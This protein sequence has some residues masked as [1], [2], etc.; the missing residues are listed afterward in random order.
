MRGK[1][2][3]D[4]R[5]AI[6]ELGRFFRNICS[7]TLKVDALLKMEADIAL[8][9]C[10]LESLYPPSFFDVMVHLAVHLPREA[11]VA[12]PVQYRWMYPIERF[13]GKLKR[14]V[15]NKARSE[16][17]IAESY[18]DN[19][20]YTF[21]SIYFHG[22]DTRFTKLDRNYEGGKMGVSSTFTVFSQK[23]HP[24]GA[25]GGYDLCGR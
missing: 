7:R 22:V 18:I 14:S 9:L 17:P 24:I 12:S 25:Q 10:K 16:G 8:I 2:T 1:L 5:T 21:C 6:T 4:V 3:P 13:L 11:L 15:G 19:V 20:W 23:V